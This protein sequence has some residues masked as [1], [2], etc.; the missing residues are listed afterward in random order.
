MQAFL[1]T[2]SLLVLCTACGGPTGR[3]KSD[4]ESDLT[5]STRAGAETFN[6]LIQES[7]D[8][9]LQKPS[10]QRPAEDRLKIAFLGVENNGIEELL[11]WR[12]TLRQRIDEAVNRS[13]RYRNISDRFVKAALNETG[14]RP[15]DLYLPE[16]R[17]RFV[18]VLEANGNPVDFLL[19]ASMNTG[20]TTAG[21]ETQRD[22]LLTLELVDVENGESEKVNADVRKEYLR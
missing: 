3:V 15:D 12:D 9:L 4:D 21:R 5:G 14:L 18:Q 22:Y 13:G 2:L 7:V 17:R 19:Y 1:A 6:R 20:T 16:K 11:D 8:N 10:A